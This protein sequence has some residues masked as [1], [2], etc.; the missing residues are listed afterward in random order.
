VP[1]AK[2]IRLLKSTC[3]KTFPRESRLTFV[4]TRGAIQLFNRY[5]ECIFAGFSGGANLASALK[6]L[7]GDYKGKNILI[8]IPDSGTKYLSTDLW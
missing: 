7:N 3:D 4:G 1:D 5:E 8:L 6:L 2:V